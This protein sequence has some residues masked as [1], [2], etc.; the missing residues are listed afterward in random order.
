LACPVKK[1][2]TGWHAAEQPNPCCIL[3][4]LAAFSALLHSDGDFI[5]ILKLQAQSLVQ[6]FCHPQLCRV[7]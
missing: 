2:H 5:C 3:I 1:R 6:S 7:E 4:L